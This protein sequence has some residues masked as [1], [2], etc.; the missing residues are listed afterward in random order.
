MSWL[1]LAIRVSP[2]SRSNSPAT[3]A[4][5]YSPTLWPMTAAGWT[6]HERHSAASA[7]SRENSAGCVNPVWWMRGSSP[8]NMTSRSGRSKRSRRKASH[9]S[10]TSA[11]TGSA[12]YSSRPIPGYC[13]PCPVNS[14][15]GRA[16]RVDSTW[17][18]TMWRPC[19]PRPRARRSSRSSSIVPATN[20]SR[21]AKASRPRLS[22]RQ[23][24]GS[25]TSWVAR[26]SASRAAWAW[27]AGSDWATAVSTS[28]GRPGADDGGRRRRRGRG[29]RGRWCRRTR[30]SSRRRSGVGPAPTASSWSGRRSAARPTGSPG[31]ARR[32]AGGAGWCRAP[33]TSIALIS[34]AMP[35]A[36]S[37]WPRLRLDRADAQAAAGR[38]IAPE[39]R[40]ECLDLDRVAELGAGAVGL[41][42]A[43][44]GRV[45]RRRRPARP[46]SPLSW[47]GPFGAVRPLLRPSWLTA[48]PLITPTT[49]SP[50]RSASASR[51]STTTPQPS[52]RTKPSAL[53]EK[54]LHRPS[55]AIICALE[56]A[57]LVTGER[58]TLTPAPRAASH[59][60]RPQR[61][62]GQVDGD[63]RR[64]A[65]G[66]D[67]QGRAGEAEQVGDAAGGHAGRGA[68][69]QVAVD[70]LQP[71]P[72]LQLPGSPW[73]RGRRRRRCGCP[74]SEPGR[75]AGPLERL[76]RLTS[77][78]SRCCGSMPTASRGEMPKS[79][80]SKRSTL[81]E[82]AA[83][84]RGHLAVGL[85]V[86][87]V[88]RRRRPSGRP[89]PR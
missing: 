16:G 53:A 83:P 27:R 35:A 86:G 5:A 17:S 40:A 65:G 46:R 79:R 13:E 54:V 38:A 15:T 12:S 45:Q 70:G 82:E 23:T 14:H 19:S 6:P 84:P 78:S 10:S 43:D 8:A 81:V 76:P 75:D 51:F 3:W 52:P 88:E 2:S 55:A 7:T 36:D 71:A 64:R 24:S 21:C 20:A 22:V 62:H 11:T 29:R 18:R 30:T 89:G 42:V 31:S 85:P 61:L 47:D 44:V 72:V 49:T 68:R 66:V 26:W 57:M 34:P 60:P 1:R 9:R 48:L 67:G 56:S 37:R 73:T 58:I 74:G 63:E 25:A 50:S 59:W 41:D 4:A 69:G 32:G 39:H 77:S 80:A 28:T 33:S 87:V